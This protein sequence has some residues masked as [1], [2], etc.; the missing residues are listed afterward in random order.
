MPLFWDRLSDEHD[1]RVH[2]RMRRNNG[3]GRPVRR[4]SADQAGSAVTRNT[5]WNI[6][7]T[8]LP[9]VFAIITIPVLI[10][11]IGT[12]SF[13]VFAIAWT[14]LS[15][16]GFLDFGIGRATIKFLAEAFEDERQE[17]ARGIFWT[18]LVLSGS[19]GC[20]NGLI[21]FAIAEPLVTRIL[22]VPAGLQSEALTAFYLLALGIP[23]VTVVRS[24]TGTI[25][26]RHKFGLYNALQMPNSAL[27]QA[28]PLLV[29]PFHNSLPWLVGSL[30]A[31]RLWGTGVFFVAALRQLDE[32]FKGP[33]FLREKLGVFISYSSWQAVTNLVSPVMESADRFI[34]GAVTSLTA[35]AYYVT[36]A[37]ITTRLLILS[38][39]L[40]RTTFP[41][42]SAQTDIRQRTRVY[43]NSTKCLAL[44]MA[45]VA[46]SVIVFASDGLRLWLGPEFA[47]NSTAVLHILAVGLL[48][49]ALATIPF[50]AIQGV[51]RADVT[52]KFHL[53]QLPVYLFLLW[54]GVTHWGIV[55]AALAWTTRVTADFLMLSFYARAKVRMD[56]G[57][58][59]EERLNQIL[60]LSSVPLAAGWLLQEMADSLLLKIPLWGLLVAAG[61]FLAWRTLLTTED[62]TKIEEYAGKA[63]S[64]K[65][66]SG[67]GGK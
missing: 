46:A 27:T 16:F 33:F 24:L 22:N 28:A 56:A 25:E 30:V 31:A 12:A 1:K 18:S 64:R 65:R 61:A 20:A 54:Y 35:V 23:L 66:A 3:S 53:I 11:S 52:A 40:G 17:E 7:G 59:A 55:G 41:I 44:V 63:V 10:G 58:L 21:L 29:L 51:G 4:I 26:A 8:G 62:R 43:A 48:A 47:Q 9:V 50:G 6:L 39:S 67:S 57:I 34:I 15:Y 45:P 13:G 49:N 60:C 42:F 37:E 19:L 5:L 32:P 2:T 38:Q 14:F 36:P